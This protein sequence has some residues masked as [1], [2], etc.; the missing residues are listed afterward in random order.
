MFLNIVYLTII[1]FINLIIKN[2]Y[3]KLFYLIIINTK[4]KHLQKPF[5]IEKNISNLGFNVG[6]FREAMGN[7]TGISLMG[8]IKN[9]KY[10]E[11]ITPATDWIGENV[12]YFFGSSN[13]LFSKQQK[14]LKTA[15]ALHL[16]NDLSID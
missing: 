6:N 4:M 14:R 3:L 1:D 7:A 10:S 12:D 9:S 8:E 2:T 16:P 11:Y 13:N 5:F 15:I